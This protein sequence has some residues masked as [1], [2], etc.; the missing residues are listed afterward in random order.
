MNLRYPAI[1]LLGDSLLQDPAFASL[2]LQ[3]YSRRAD[4]LIRAFGGFNSGWLLELLPDLL[5]H[6]EPA[7]VCLAVLLIGTNDACVDP[8]HRVSLYPS[9]SCEL[10]SRRNRSIT[11]TTSAKSSISLRRTQVPPCY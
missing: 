4:V 5:L 3:R 11:E 6:V 8:P 10:T 1:L 7:A 9:W 2:A